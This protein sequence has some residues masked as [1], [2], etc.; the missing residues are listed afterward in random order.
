MTFQNIVSHNGL[1]VPNYGIMLES[2]HALY[3]EHQNSLWFE[4]ASALE[5]GPVLDSDFDVDAVVIGAGFTGLRAALR[6]AEAGTRVVV[7]DAF[8]VGWGASGRSGGQVNPMLPFN[9]PDQI[10]KLVGPGFFESLTQVSLNSADE[11]FELIKT[12]KIDCQP[13]QNGW[14]RVD[15]CDKARRVS[16]SNAEIWNRLGADMQA[17]EGDEVRRLSGSA[18]YRSGIVVPKGGSVQPLSLARGL[19]RAAR[20]AGAEIYSRS[21][22]SALHRNGAKW[23]VETAR[24]KVTTDWVILATN[25]YSDEL[26]SG[27][28]KSI[29]PL[30]PIQIAT[31]PLKPEQIAEI[32]PHG[33][34]IS[35]TRR[36][37]MYARRERD[38]RMVFG[39]HGHLDKNNQA[40]GFDWLVHDVTRIFPQ[41]EG[42]DW[43]Y[44]WGGKIA[45]TEDRL[46]HFHEPKPGLIAGLGYNGRGVAMSHVMGKWLAERALGAQPES[47][48]FPTTS[49]KA[50]SFRGI[51]MMGE[52]SAIRWM[53]LLDKL[54]SK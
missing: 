34:T 9:T 32:L 30:V 31:A 14:L 15:H 3:S 16:R 47:L 5:P 46:P 48:P 27:L 52:S 2:D 37:I 26:F 22:V 11:L 41:L 21:P 33:H 35:D 10:R 42:V 19:A 44:R 54:E 1:F 12:Y 28:A 13:R 50:M 8:D 18:I 40:A 49:I 53:R 36:I 4:T 51:Q 25:G 7:I 43:R 38:D 39:G 6:L 29:L 45:L 23:L 24:A 20:D 17:V